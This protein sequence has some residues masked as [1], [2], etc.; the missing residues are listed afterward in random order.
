[1]NRF[2]NRLLNIYSRRHEPSDYPNIC[3]GSLGDIVPRV[4]LCG[5]DDMYYEIIPPTSSVTLPWS[6][7]AYT[8]NYTVNTY[9]V[10]D[11]GGIADFN[12]SSAF[13]FTPTFSINNTDDDKTVSYTDTRCFGGKNF[14][15]VV[16][17]TKCTDT[18]LLGYKV[19]ITKFEYQ[20][21]PA[22]GGTIRNPSITYDVYKIWGNAATSSKTSDEKLYSFPR[23][24]LNYTYDIVDVYD[25]RIKDD[26]VQ[27]TI[28][29][30]GTFTPN[31]ASLGTEE[32][33][34]VKDLVKLRL[35]LS[36]KE[37]DYP[38]YESDSKETIVQ[39]DINVL[40]G[41]D[42]S[43]GGYDDPDA[44]EHRE[45]TNLYLSY[46]TKDQNIVSSDTIS[47]TGGTS[48][49]LHSWLKYKRQY[50]SGAHTEPKYIEDCDIVK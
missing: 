25:D 30:N 46:D 42:G 48:K 37:P 20:N 6:A 34:Q 14:I 49:Q 29:A 16:T 35:N 28:D 3:C 39:Q 13:T 19:E 22:S 24:G 31:I 40:L 33:Y 45:Y 23:S 1:M 27:K 50:S 17:Q 8:F 21:I 18:I 10:Y 5:E 7:T 41:G 12:D 44:E 47:F 11:D 4:I 36:T 38:C 2:N 43:D 15:G 9:C 32:T 26:S